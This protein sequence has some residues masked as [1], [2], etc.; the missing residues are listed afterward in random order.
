MHKVT[1]SKMH[2]RYVQTVLTFRITH[3]IEPEFFFTLTASSQTH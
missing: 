3:V 1:V 2:E